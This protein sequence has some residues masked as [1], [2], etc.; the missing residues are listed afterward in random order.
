MKPGWC[1]YK[2]RIILDDVYLPL[3]VTVPL[4]QLLDLFVGLDGRPCSH[5]LIRRHASTLQLPLQVQF[6]LLQSAKGSGK[7]I[8]VQRQNQT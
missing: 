4:L 5:H 8:S 1:F 7:Y 6:L 2:F 3:Q